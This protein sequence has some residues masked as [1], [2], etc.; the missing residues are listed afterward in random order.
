MSAGDRSSETVSPSAGSIRRS[1][2]YLPGR[3]TPIFAWLYCRPEGYDRRHGVIICPPA[4]YKQVHAHRALRHLAGRLAAE[5][6]PV[7]SIDPHGTGDS[8]GVGE[9][10]DRLDTWL[11]NIG[12]SLAWMR[13]TLGCERVTLLG[14]RMG[15]TLAALVARTQ[16]VDDLILWAPVVS[17]RQ[18]ARELKVLSS[19][20]LGR[21][22]PPPQDGD[23]IEPAGFVVTAETLAGISKID[24]AAE[25]VQCPS[26]W[27]LN[28]D[29]MP[30]DV[31]LAN[32]LR[33]DGVAIESTVFTGFAGMVAL[34]H[35]SQL[36]EE[37]LRAIVRRMIAVRGPDTGAGLTPPPR[38]LPDTVSFAFQPDPQQ[39]PATLSERPLLLGSA[40]A[41]FGILTE[42]PSAGDRPLLLFINGGASYRIGPNRLYV[43]MARTLALDGFRSVRLDLCGLG[44]SLTDDV[45]RENKS[46]PE[47]FLRDIDLAINE[48]AKSHGVR[49]V[50]LVGLCAGAY[51][52]YRAAARL[53]NPLLV[54]S[55]VIN[56]LTFHWKEGMPYDAPA[57]AELRDLQ[58][59]LQMAFK[60]GKWL[61]LLSGKSDISVRGAFKMLMSHRRA[62]NEAEKPAGNA[63]SVAV[64][65]A[66]TPNP[67]KASVRDLLPDQSDNIP[68][69]LDKIA[70]AGRRIAFFFSRNDQG[71]HI[72]MYAAKRTVQ[73]MRR[74]RKL[75]L[76]FIED[77][78]H[79]LSARAARARLIR[80]VRA[81]LLAS[82]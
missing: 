48:L 4:V 55:I 34:P 50:I 21:D 45:T 23:D 39:P 18:Y 16:P 70:R 79:T 54:Q 76:A 63:A 68:D 71:Q 64:S 51:H 8:P 80:L 9:D 74:A 12:D 20:T 65:G 2:F 30:E 36:P 32:R 53:D 1:A 25:A 5:S 29:D 62:L 82:T 24:L 19:V 31:R 77:A 56:P 33:S 43:Q 59:Y 75:E 67:A 7:L 73:K 35:H 69:E 37:A 41:L 40:P 57:L 38:A 61:R 52:A 11:Q 3:G 22:K 66:A 44:D 17:G 14:F 58:Y 26:V 49:K 81:S 13:E 72:L 42:P 10:P 78:D 46:Y 27:L 60:P 6:F 47:T 28:R 15:A